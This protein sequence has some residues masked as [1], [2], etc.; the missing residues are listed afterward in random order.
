MK[1]GSINVCGLQSKL[2][3]DD[4]CQFLQCHD[5]LFVCETKLG[6]N[7]IL[8]VSGYNFY[9]TC[10]KN[11]K[12]NSGGVGVFI[13][14]E[15]LFF[16]TFINSSSDFTLWLRFDKKMFS[17]DKDVL[18]SVFCAL[19]TYHLKTHLIQILKCSTQ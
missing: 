5:I 4:L 13:K 12:R 17:L 2:I 15:L 18:C 3:S 1:I 10:R 16:T 9:R 19:S 11:A 8:N 14:K 7:D 6:E